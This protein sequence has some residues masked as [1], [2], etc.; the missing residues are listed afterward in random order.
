MTT[1]RGDCFEQD[2]YGWKQKPCEFKCQ[3]VNCPNQ[4]CNF[5]GPQ[6][7]LDSQGGMCLECAM[8]LYA[9]SQEG[10]SKR[11]YQTKEKKKEVLSD[12]KSLHLEIAG[13]PPRGNKVSV[14]EL[15]KLWTG[16]GPSYYPDNFKRVIVE[17]SKEKSFDEAIKEWSPVAVEIGEDDGYC[18]CS[19]DIHIL[20]NIV[21]IVTQ[22][23][24]VVGCDCIEKL[25]KGTLLAVKIDQLDSQV[26]HLSKKFK[27][28]ESLIHFPCTSC[29]KFRT[30]SLGVRCKSCI[31]EGLYN[32]I[33]LIDMKKL[34]GGGIL[35]KGKHVGRSYLSVSEEDPSYCLFLN[36]EADCEG[37][38]DFKQWIKENDIIRKI[39]EKKLYLNVPFS[40]KE[41]AKKLGCKWDVQRKKWWIFSTKDNLDK[42]KRWNK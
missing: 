18:I 5:K 27:E 7:F 33:C 6:Y 2:E 23:E 36:K 19:H 10:S 28:K 34:C 32:N 21:N 20:Y 12:G 24:V 16:K 39:E 40:E 35:K 9:G 15:S 41:E 17:Y 14:D 25:A 13:A 22:N 30:S 11:V 8:I 42:V 26:K 1:C 38:E 29:G 31:E 4:R 37:Y 3:L